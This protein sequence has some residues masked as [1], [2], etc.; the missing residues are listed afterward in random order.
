MGEERPVTTRGVRARRR[1]EQRDGL[2]VADALRETLDPETLSSHLRAIAHDVR[3]PRDRLA[4]LAVVV[5]VELGAR[6]ER[7]APRIPGLALLL[8]AAGSV[9]ADEEAVAVLDLDRIVPA[10]RS[11][12]HGRSIVT[13][14]PR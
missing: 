9:P 2:P 7:V 5:G 8:H 4:V 13:M 6:R 14:V 1:A 10:F 3:I 11:H 12:R